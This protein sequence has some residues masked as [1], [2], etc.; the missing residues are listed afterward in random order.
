MNPGRRD[1]ILASGKP[2]SGGGA[3]AFAELARHIARG[4]NSGFPHLSHPSG[5]W[6]CRQDAHRPALG[7]IPL[8]SEAVDSGRSPLGISAPIIGRRSTR[9]LRELLVGGIMN[10]TFYREI[11]SARVF[12]SLQPP[13]EAVSGAL[14][15]SEGYHSDLLVSVH[16]LGEGRFILNSLNIRQH[17]GHVPAAEH[18][19]RNMLNYAARDMGKPPAALPADFDAQLGSL[20]HK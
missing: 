7:T 10:Y 11:L 4:A 15:T 8:G 18:L 17:L 9:F 2:P 16:T 13:L 6:N 3:P 20:G 14:D 1:V 5:P 12:T 19:L